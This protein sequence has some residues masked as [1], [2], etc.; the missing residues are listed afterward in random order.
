MRYEQ[1]ADDGSVL[2][3]HNVIIDLREAT[4][5]LST[6]TTIELKGSPLRTQS[7]DTFQSFLDVGY[8]HRGPSS[9]LM[10]N[11]MSVD[12]ALDKFKFA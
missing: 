6:I 5:P 9:T 7:S 4:F 2:R 11:M 1:E 3:E 8:C 12:Q 10:E